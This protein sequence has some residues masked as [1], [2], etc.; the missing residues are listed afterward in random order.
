MDTIGDIEEA[1]MA[2][3]K[4]AI[5][6]GDTY[7]A[8]MAKELARK[9]KEFIEIYGFKDIKRMPD[10]PPVSCLRIS[11]PTQYI[12]DPESATVTISKKLINLTP[13]ENKLFLLLTQN[14]STIDKLK[15]LTSE[16]IRKSIWQ[17]KQVGKSA[18]RILIKRVR[19]KIEPNPLNPEILVSYN[20]KG[21][22]FFA[23]SK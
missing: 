10:S 3:Y 16:Y 4:R 18:V 17:K 21:Y 7:Q 9:L 2:N 8:R 5:E 1:I 20:K 6:N 12:Y 23:K 22:I 19:K 14:E 15:I 11:R 13:T